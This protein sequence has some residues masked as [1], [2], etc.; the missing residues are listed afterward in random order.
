MLS[1]TDGFFVVFFLVREV[2]YIPFF[3][4]GEKVVFHS[5]IAS[6]KLLTHG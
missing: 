3:P 6:K 2:D 4:L 1:D 5:N